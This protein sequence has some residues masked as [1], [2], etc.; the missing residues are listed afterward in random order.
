MAWVSE[1]AVCVILGVVYMRMNLPEKYRGH[2]EATKQEWGKV[3][4][5]A[6]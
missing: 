1:G 2:R 5:T 4:V 6:G 3:E